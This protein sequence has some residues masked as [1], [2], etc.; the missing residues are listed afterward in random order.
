VH[1]CEESDDLI[2]PAKR[3]NKAGPWAA[4]ELVEGRRSREGT[5]P[6]VDHFPETVPESTGGVGDGT[7]VSPFS[8]A[9]ASDPSEE[10][11]EVI[12]HVPS[13]R[14]AARE[15]GPYRDTYLPT[16]PGGTAL[17]LPATS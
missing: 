5:V 6:I 12:L 16:L 10:P 3:A 17:A 13:V 8:V 7:T 11:Y 2:V 9:S 1:V 4:A 15:G 14:G